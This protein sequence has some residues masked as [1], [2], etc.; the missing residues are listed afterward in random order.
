VGTVLE[1]EVNLLDDLTVT[2]AH[3][4]PNVLLFD[5][6]KS[7]KDSVVDLLPAAARAG[8]ETTP[9]VP[10]RIVSV[11]GRSIEDLR[12][13]TAAGR[14]PERWALRRIYRNTY[15]ARLGPAETLISGRWWDGTPGSENGRRVD[16]HGL[17]RVSLEEG[18]AQDLHV[19]L[20]DRIT[21]NVGGV[22]VASIVTSIRKVEWTRLE[23]NFFAVFEP[24]A[25]ADAP[26][27]FVV[28]ARV[29][30]AG[31]RATL[32]RA[33][34]S[35]F[36]NVSALDFSRVRAAVD[37]VLGR[38]RQAVTFLGLFS[39]LAGVLVLLGALATSR[40]QRLRE[41]ALLRT[42]G[43]RRRQV[44]IVLLSEY[45]ALGT[46]ATASGLVLSWVAAAIVVPHMFNLHFT[47]HVRPLTIVWLAVTGVTVTVGL[48][49]SRGL[50]R[51]APLAVLR[52]AP[53]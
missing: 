18:I 24:G 45:L 49:G 38:V 13:D 14:H 15:R 25:L 48:L 3:S 28:L 30:D 12:R 39:G 21:W 26:Q 17:A 40:V 52:E 34:V 51:R 7:Q 20:G 5:V 11:N 6:Q 2:F 44:L 35:R 19:G 46:L 42:L 32:Q 50:L 36:P 23:P 47:T 37:A 8:A 22:D 29:P 43:A 1:V 4:R 53:E 33:L 9:I 41:G 16:A 27:T 10:G 31:E